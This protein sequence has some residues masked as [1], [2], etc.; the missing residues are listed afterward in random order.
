MAAMA[1][2]VVDLGSSANSELVSFAG[3]GSE[4]EGRLRML[5]RLIRGAWVTVGLALLH[6]GVL[7]LSGWVEHQ[8]VGPSGRLGVWKTVCCLPSSNTEYGGGGLGF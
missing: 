8:G 6:V 5:G 1:D 2:T 4:S 7:G 3:S